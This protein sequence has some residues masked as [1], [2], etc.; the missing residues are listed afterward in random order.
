M[1]RKWN[2]GMGQGL[3]KLQLAILIRGLELLKPGGKLVYSTCTMNPYENEAV[4]A[5]AVR[6]FSGKV[7]LVDTT[8]DLPNLKRQPGLLTWKVRGT[9]E[10]DPW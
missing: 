7:V 1:W 8:K 5:E 9:K 2:Y 6:R 10:E 3:H 4:L